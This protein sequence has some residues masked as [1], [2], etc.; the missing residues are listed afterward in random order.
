MSKHDDAA[1]GE[2]PLGKAESVA[3]DG[4]GQQPVTA[5]SGRCRLLT[6]QTGFL[7]LKLGSSCSRSGAGNQ[8]E[9]AVGDASPC[10][11][12]DCFCRIVQWHL[13]KICGVIFLLW[14]RPKHSV[15][16]R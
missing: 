5:G 7:W 14:P 13:D 4:S 9:P 2:L 6:Q 15:E 1:N 3:G 11:T 10:I 12:H 8:L 16:E